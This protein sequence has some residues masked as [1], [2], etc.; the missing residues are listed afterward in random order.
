MPPTEFGG[1]VRL[2]VS[3]AEDRVFA[4]VGNKREI[5]DRIID[6]AVVAGYCEEAM[7]Q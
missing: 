1:G 5:M 4:S 3:P 2:A 7:S 6:A